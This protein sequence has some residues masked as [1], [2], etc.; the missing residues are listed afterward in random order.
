M[1]G[2][3]NLGEPLRIIRRDDD[4]AVWETQN[5]GSRGIG[6]EGAVSPQRLVAEPAGEGKQSPI[7]E[8][9]ATG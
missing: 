1:S 4:P 5:H 6:G 2:L 3:Q 8:T 9:V 7:A